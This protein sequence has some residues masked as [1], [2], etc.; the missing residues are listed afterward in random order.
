VI[1]QNVKH[2]GLTYA[3]IPAI[4]SEKYWEQRAIEN[5]MIKEYAARE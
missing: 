1:Y 5:I 4:E 3:G 2:P